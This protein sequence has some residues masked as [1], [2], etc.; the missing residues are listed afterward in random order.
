MKLAF[1]MCIK[2]SFRYVLYHQARARSPEPS[3]SAL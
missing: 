3:M 1:F 2:V